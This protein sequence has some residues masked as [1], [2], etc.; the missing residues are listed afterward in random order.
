VSTLRRI[1]FRVSTSRAI[2]SC[3]LLPGDTAVIAQIGD[4]PNWHA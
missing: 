4:D 1:G 2:G 3:P